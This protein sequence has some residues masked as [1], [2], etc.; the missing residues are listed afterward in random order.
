[1]IKHRRRSIPRTQMSHL[2]WWTRQR[3]L[4]RGYSL[5][6]WTLLGLLLLSPAEMIMNAN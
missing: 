1:M 2:S 5:T 4:M 6:G 3:S